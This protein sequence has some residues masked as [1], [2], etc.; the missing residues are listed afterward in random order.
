MIDLRKG[1]CLELMKDIPDKSID[2]VVIDPPYVLETDGAGMFG[3]KAEN[4]GGERYVMKN[5]DFMKNGISNE[6]LDELVRV[7]KKNNIYIWCSQ[8]QLPIFYKYFVEKKKCNWNLLTWHKSNPT[9]TCGNKYLTD[10][11]FCLFFRDKGVKV[12]GEY[13]TKRTYYVTTKN[14]QDKKLYKHPTI[15]PLDIIKNLIINSSNKNDVVLDC[16]MGSGTTGVACKELDRKFIG[17]EINEEYFN[18]A[19]NRI[20][21]AGE[22]DKNQLSLF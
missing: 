20:E 1:D 11:E 5:I 3:K 13:A 19:K 22:V 18:I 14:L 15:K 8:K 12:Y 10:T 17:I 6:V 9:P 16:F 21:E 4:Y 2:L 7:M